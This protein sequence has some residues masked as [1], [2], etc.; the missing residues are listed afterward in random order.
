MGDY[1]EELGGFTYDP[2]QGPGRDEW[3]DLDESERD[4]A[5][6][7]THERITESHPE[8][9]NLDLHI[10]IHAIV[11]TQIALGD[12]PATGATLKRLVADLTLDK[13]A[14]KDVLSKKW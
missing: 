8:T 10:Q 3:L 13:E 6:R 1:D 4:H 7:L 2:Q 14:L 5:I 9:P 12:P 11:E